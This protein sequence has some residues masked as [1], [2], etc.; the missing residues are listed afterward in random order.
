MYVDFCDHIY[1]NMQIYQV[2]SRNDGAVNWMQLVPIDDCLLFFEF[3][4]KCC[5]LTF[6]Y[7]TKAEQQRCIMECNITKF[8]NCISLG[9][10]VSI[11]LFK[12]QITELLRHIYSW[13]SCIYE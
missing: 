6:Y 2:I 13:Q 8:A 5:L 3:F 12:C 11:V 10:P 7:F 4:L 9:L 1:L